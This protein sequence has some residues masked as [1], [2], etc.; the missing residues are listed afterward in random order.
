MMNQAQ[1]TR[2]ADSGYD[3]VVA[4]I[5]RVNI[6]AFCE[7]EHSAK[8]MQAVAADRRMS[9]AHMDVQLGGIAA[10]CQVFAGSQTPAVLIV[11]SKENRDG[12]LAALG[13]LAQVCDAGTR[14]IVIGHVNDVLLYRELVSQGISEYLVGP[15]H[16][17]QVIESLA[18]L[19]K[20]KQCRPHRPRCRLRR[21]Q[22][23]CRFFDPGAQYRLAGVQQ[24]FDRHGDHRP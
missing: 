6:Q 4:S 12:V 9:K 19:F 14:V 20:Q 11:E 2:T 7:D 8:V 15:V 24:L 23:R 1:D 3:E 22:G 18:S 17:L 21:H 5:P 16:Q 10:A 13:Q